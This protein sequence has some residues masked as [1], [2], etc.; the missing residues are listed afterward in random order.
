[1]KSMYMKELYKL[2]GPIKHMNLFFAE[3]TTGPLLLLSLTF[4]EHPPAPFYFLSRDRSSNSTKSHP[5]ESTTV[6]ETQ[7]VHSITLTWNSISSYNLY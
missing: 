3:C 2:A 7:M 6:W 5:I 1:M 4:H